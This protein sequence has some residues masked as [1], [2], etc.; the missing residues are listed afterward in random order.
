MINLFGFPR[1]AYGNGCT[2]VWRVIWWG[3]AL[4]GGLILM[5]YIFKEEDL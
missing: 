2:C 4:E 3:L 5:C 1:L